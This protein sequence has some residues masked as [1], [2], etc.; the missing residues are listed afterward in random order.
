MVWCRASRLVTA[1]GLALG[2]FGC[3]ISDHSAVA[4]PQVWDDWAVG[5]V[6][7]AKT[8]QAVRVA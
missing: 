4:R 8:G 6:L 2:M 5:Q 7:D 3:Q 1:L